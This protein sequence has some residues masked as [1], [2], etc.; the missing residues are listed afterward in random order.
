MS[1]QPPHI[2]GLG[3]LSLLA[4]ILLILDLNFARVTFLNKSHTQTIKINGNKNGKVFLVGAGPG[5]PDLL[6][7]KAHRVIQTADIIFYDRLISPAIQDLFPAHAALAYV[8]KARGAHSV[9]QDE[10][11]ALLIA[12][13]RQGRNVCRLKGGDPFVFGRGGE[14]MA[15]LMTAGIDV[16]IVPGI[17][18]ALGCAAYAGIPLTHRDVSQA[19]TLVTACGADGLNVD[20]QAL[21]GLG[22]TIVFYMGLAECSTIRSSLVAAG[23]PGQT[24]VA[25]IERG[26][27]EEQRTICG[28]LDQL[29]S[30]PG[31]YQV[32]SPALIIVGEVA[33]FA[34]DFHWFGRILPTAAQELSA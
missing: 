27:T 28:T 3:R 24:P 6:T 17:T 19:V 26:T 2:D 16:E 14:E 34:N 9:P 15:A 11:Q 32:Q 31:W 23:K 5:D 8:G 4:P 1:Q 21:A 22:H 10:L 29:A 33:A 13:A 30:L 20:W 25:L 7:L 18:A 12:A